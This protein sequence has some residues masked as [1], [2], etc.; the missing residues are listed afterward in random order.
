MSDILK[1]GE[2]YYEFV[3]AVAR[4]ARKIAD[5]ERAILES[6]KDSTLSRPEKELAL[7]ADKPVTVAVQKFFTG[8]LKLNDPSTK[9]EEESEEE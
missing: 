8:E 3:V 7:K 2:S 1:P 5:E 9:E 6:D 4:E